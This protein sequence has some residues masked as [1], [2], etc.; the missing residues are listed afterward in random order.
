MKKNVFVIGLDDHNT[1]I[2]KTLRQV[3]NGEIKIRRLLDYEET[4]GAA[5]YPIEEMLRKS[6][7]VLNDFPGP[8]DAVTAFWDFPVSCMVPILCAKYDMPT[9][10]LESVLKCE[11]KY[12]SRTEQRK[13]IPE[14]IPGFQSFDPFDDA[15]LD[16]LR[17]NLRFPF[18]IKPIKSFGSHLGFRIRNEKDWQQAIPVIRGNIG[19]FTDPLDYVMDLAEVPEEIAGNDDICIAEEIIS[20]RQC[21]LEGYVYNGRVKVYGVVDSIRYAHLPS[22]SRYQYP[23][24]L[25]KTAQKKMIEIARR[26]MRHVGYDNRT[27]NV[28]FF[29]D[30]KNDHPWLLEVNTRMAQSHADLF[31]KVDGASSHEIMADLSL[32]QEPDFPHREGDYGCAGKFFVRAFRDGTVTR[33]PTEQ[34]IAEAK[35]RFP[36]LIVQPMVREGMSLSQLLYQDSYSYYLAILY[37]GA[38]NE[39]DLLKKYNECV[40]FLDFQVTDLG[41]GAE[42]RQLPN[43]DFPIE[44]SIGGES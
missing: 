31:Y 14:Y 27:F 42:T 41:H 37:M 10:S 32:G 20:G 7:R 12:W 19:T 18:W 35:E 6:V 26:L 5:E 29:Y 34:R 24:H 13:V 16:K 38:R 23:S 9:A 4:H 2:L 11:H 3:Q 21:T 1:E 28:E 30:L 17:Q 43:A 22:F 8:V 40:D 15:A 39:R 36:G 25:P 44:A 33:V